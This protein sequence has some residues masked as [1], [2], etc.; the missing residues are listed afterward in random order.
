MVEERRA[1][2]RAAAEERERRVRELRQDR[3]A[4]QEELEAV[5]AEADAAGR[6]L[7]S[8]L[9]DHG[10]RGDRCTVELGPHRLVGVVTHVG[11]DVVRL[12]DLDGRSRDVAVDR[13]ALVA[14]QS[15]GRAA[16]A[17]GSGHPVTLLARA[18]ELV[19]AGGRVEI[20]R[21]DVPGTLVGRLVAAT[22]THLE[23]D[24]G[25][26]GPVLLAWPAVAWLSG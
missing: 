8:A 10:E 13:I 2:G 9:R 6:T 7:G 11:D 1:A 5:V 15:A 19:V 18:R 23:L 14:R 26:A 20:G 17:V 22:A 21:V 3:R 25:A 12:V 4:R 16:H 24:G